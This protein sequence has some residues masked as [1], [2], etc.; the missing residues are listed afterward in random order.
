MGG[1]NREALRKKTQTTQEALNQQQQDLA[2]KRPQSGSKFAGYHTIEVGDNIFRIAPFH[3]DGGGKTYAEAKTV[4]FLEVSVPKKDKEGNV[5]EGQEEIK[6]RGIFNAKVHGNLPIDPGE[7]YM[8]VAKDLAI[9]NFCDQDTEKQQEI[10]EFITGNAVKKIDGIKPQDSWVVWA[11]KANGK[12]SDGNYL[13][14]DWQR[15]ELKRS[16]K[17]GM[18]ERA[19]ELGMPDPYSDIDEGVPVIITK[20]DKPKPNEKRKPTDWYKVRLDSEKKGLN[21]S[22]KS[23]PLTDSQLE[24][25]SKL[26]PLYELF[27]NTYTRNDLEKQLEGLQRFDNK[28]QEKFGSGVSIFQYEE[29]T[30][31]VDKLFDIV[32]EP[33]K[34]KG[35]EEEAPIEEEH[36]ETSPE[37]TKQVQQQTSRVNKPISSANNVRQSKPAK[38]EEE[39]VAVEKLSEEKLKSSTANS[40]QSIRARL[41]KK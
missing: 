4:S 16:I 23:A 32:Q 41:G 11:L 15:T 5:I 2:S 29:F 22:Y 24:A 8:Q 30:D 25:W 36:V 40:L 17:D 35:I 21:I 31:P 38:N 6:K 7:L 37:P 27:V 34:E 33:K 14:S 13:W 19:A 12:D 26:T 20:A 1:F 39:E 3:P 18:A 10:W 28:L 9:P